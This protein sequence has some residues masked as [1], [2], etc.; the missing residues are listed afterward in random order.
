MESNLVFIISSSLFCHWEKIIKW[1][2]WS[3]LKT[4]TAYFCLFLETLLFC[5]P[6]KWAGKTHCFLSKGILSLVISKGIIF[7]VYWDQEHNSKNP[8]NE[9]LIY[10]YSHFS[11]KKMVCQKS[12]SVYKTPKYAYLGTSLSVNTVYKKITY[13]N[14]KKCNTTLK[15]WQPTIRLYLS[16]F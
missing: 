7:Q 4:S 1:L 2:S 16:A 13:R 9:P 15:N 12:Y 6:S 5:G 14:R 11:A 10:I 8:L 3:P